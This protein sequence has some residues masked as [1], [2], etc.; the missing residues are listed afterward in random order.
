[1]KKIGIIIQARVNS[2]RL[3]GKVLKYLDDKTLIQWVIKRLKKTQVKTIILAT[4]NLNDNLKLKKVCDQENIEFFSGS[5]SNV[6]DRFY[7]AAKK[8]K[9]DAIIRVCADNPFVDSKEIDHIIKAYKKTNFKYDYYF[10]HRNYNKIA[11][12]DGFGAEL[13]KFSTL[14]K[15]YKNALVK[16]DK[17]HVTSLIWGKKIHFDM[18]PCKTSINKKY[19]HIV[20]D[21]NNLN[22]YIKIKKFIDKKKITIHDS[23]KKI[24]KLFSLYEIDEYL[25]DL[26]NVN[27][28][29]AGNENRKTLNYIKNE[30]PYLPFKIKS[31]SSDQKV[32]DWKIPKEWNLKNGYIKDYKGNHIIDIKNNYLHVA[33]Y[34]QPIKK[35]ISFYDLKKKIFTAKLS[36]AIPY[37]TL[38]YKKDWAFCMNKID[39]KKINKPEFKNKKF[40]I[41]IDSEF[42][43]GKMNYGEIVIPGKS[44]KEVLISTYICHPSMANDNLSGI[45]L[46]TLLA[47][48]INNIPNLKW[49]YR[50]IFVPETIG[51]I[52]YINENL[53]LFK[54]IDFGLNISCVGGKGD[55]S[56]KESWN[57]NHF[58]NQLVKKFFKK[59]KIK[60]K[61]FKYDIHGSDERQ[62][63]YCGSSVNI[64]SIH[65][66]KFY[67]YK[68]YH[69]SLDNLDFVKDIQIFE[70]FLIYKRVIQELEKQEIYKLKNE[71]CE[72]MLSKYDLYPHAGGSILPTQKINN[73]T[74]KILWILFETNGRN[75]LSEIAEKIGIKKNEMGNI[76]KILK[77][78]KIIKHV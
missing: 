18:L 75:T 8:Y 39:Y 55:I 50:V 66:D 53:D 20:C 47:R 31:F 26:F 24:S 77:E 58:I 70:T 9:L 37:R 54:K 46:T 38:Y 41:C 19:H 52:A 25:K 68:E 29:L 27:R 11:Y 3:R 16:S 10:N 44:K 59:N 21:I 61:N 36:K 45:I 49:S 4:G 5:E 43:K 14:D 32:F 74:D 35:K 63:S 17:E 60:F 1:M 34:S 15:L 67:D 48:Y 12:A 51:A 69:T 23:S 2:I 62:Y 64:A 22:D 7:H 56:F 40:E 65:K 42:K 28:S 76:I 78:K 30:L 72:P 57:T 73:L 71:Y 33:S 6:L 13:F